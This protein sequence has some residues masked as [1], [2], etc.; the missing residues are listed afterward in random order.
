MDFWNRLKFIIFPLKRYIPNIFVILIG[1]NPNPCLNGGSCDEA[2][3]G[4]TCTCESGFTG[5]ICENPPSTSPCGGVDCQYKH[6][7]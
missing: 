1:C 5:D 2:D 7:Y 4:F 3:S 6:F